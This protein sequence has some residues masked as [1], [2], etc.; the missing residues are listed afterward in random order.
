MYS[1]LKKIPVIGDFIIGFAIVVVLTT[2]SSAGGFWGF[3]GNEKKLMINIFIFIG[4]IYFL[5]SIIKRLFNF[6]KEKKIDK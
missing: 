5:L 4:I 3:E 6:F 1:D 2:L